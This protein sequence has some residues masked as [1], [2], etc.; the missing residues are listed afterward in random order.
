MRICMITFVL[1]LLV[2]CNTAGPHF[3]GVPAT[4]VSIDGSTFDV[5]VRARLAEAVRINPEYAP[6][7][8]PIAGRAKTAM[9]QVSGC[10]VTEVRGDAA[11]ATGVLDCGQGVLPR[12]L[13]GQTW[14]CFAVDGF[15]SAGLEVRHVDYECERVL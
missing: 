5:R 11:Q 15:V 14:E 2:G 7:F 10:D 1:A 12:W 8:G 4:R 6:R 9:A 13:P 3:R